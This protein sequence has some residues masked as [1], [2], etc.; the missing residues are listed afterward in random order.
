MVYF[1]L[2]ISSNKS[3]FNYEFPYDFFEK[4]LEIGLVKL[5]GILEINEKIKINNTNNKFTYIVT[6]LDKNNNINNNEFNI[7]ITKGNYDFDELINKI[8]E[9]LQKRDKNFFKIKIKK[10]NFI[11]EIQTGYS[12]IYNQNNSLLK[13][14]GIDSK[15]ENGKHSFKNKNYLINDIFLKCNLIDNIYVNNKNINSIYRFNLGVE[16]KYIQTSEIIYHKVINK[17]NK[18][19]LEL[20][21]IN[22][23]L[24]D[25]NNINIFVELNLKEK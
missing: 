15:L 6:E 23:N 16:N 10:D 20:V 2:Q 8:N 5:D 22:D 17:P 7:Q 24:V 14:F 21:D 13:V 4:N 1:N 25:F 18:I 19:S 11:I 9:L 3:T 12:I